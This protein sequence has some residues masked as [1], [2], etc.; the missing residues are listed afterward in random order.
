MYRW[1]VKDYIEYFMLWILAIFAIGVS[2][3]KFYFDFMSTKEIDLNEY[4]KNS[5]YN[6]SFPAS[7]ERVSLKIYKCYGSFYTRYNSHARKTNVELF[8]YYFVIG[9]DDGSVMAIE[10]YTLKVKAFDKITESTLSN[11][12]K[13]MIKHSGMLGVIDDSDGEIKEKYDSFIKDL[14]N[15]Q[16][17]P[18]NTVVRY[19]C[20]SNIGSRKSELAISI[21]IFLFGV[22]LILLIFSRNKR[23][24]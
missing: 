15:H 20:I 4:L 3:F 12:K 22:I 9:L 1:T 6:N 16:I 21:G 13:T 2:V 7:G 23:Y 14:K 24:R 5:S 19:E 11:G 10:T 8:D 18:Q 17:I